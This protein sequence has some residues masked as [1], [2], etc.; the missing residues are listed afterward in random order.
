MPHPTGWDKHRVDR[1]VLT[2]VVLFAKVSPE[3]NA[4]FDLVQQALTL[5]RFRRVARA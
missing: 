4:A 2:A 1:R 5:A 3:A